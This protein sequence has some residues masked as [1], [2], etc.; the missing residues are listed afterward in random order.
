MKLKTHVTATLL[1][2][3]ITITT[4]LS[5]SLSPSPVSASAV[6]CSQGNAHLASDSLLSA[7]ET[8]VKRSAAGMAGAIIGII[9]SAVVLVI[10]FWAGCKKD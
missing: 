3:T 5:L 2:A 7:R 4:A 1:L 9:A 8:I 10:V 6:S